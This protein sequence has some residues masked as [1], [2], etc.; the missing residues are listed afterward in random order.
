[1]KNLSELM[2]Y[3]VR[4]CLEKL[5][6]SELRLFRTYRIYLWPFQPIILWSAVATPDAAIDRCKPA[7]SV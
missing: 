4:Q 2:K 5:E 6:K 3:L 7:L 1:M